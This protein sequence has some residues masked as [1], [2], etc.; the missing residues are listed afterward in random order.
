ML[1]VLVTTTEARDRLMS[2]QAS[3]GDLEPWARNPHAT[4]VIYLVSVISSAS[5]HIRPLYESLARDLREFKETW[6]PDFAVGFGIACGPAGLHHMAG[7]GFRLLEGC[8]YQGHYP[9][10]TIDS[11]GAVTK[12][13]QELLN[14]G[15][16]R[17]P[18]GASISPVLFPFKA[19][20]CSPQRHV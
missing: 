5:D 6:D 18:S 12:F 10:M 17:E 1:S 20:D 14:H 3:E 19:K 7:N 15:A 11:K 16:S 8:S 9:L 13:W 4:P 2:G